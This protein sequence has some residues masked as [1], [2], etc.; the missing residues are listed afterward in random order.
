MISGRDAEKAVEFRISQVSIHSR[1]ANRR[2]LLLSQVARDQI[3]V[4]GK[5]VG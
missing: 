4:G 2:L 1:L 3:L 5:V